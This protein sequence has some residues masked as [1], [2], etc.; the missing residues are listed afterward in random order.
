MQ[1]TGVLAGMTI[2]PA[3][4][5]E[6]IILVGITRMMPDGDYDQEQFSG[7]ASI[8]LQ[9]N[10][11]NLVRIACDDGQT[12]EYPFDPRTLERAPPGEYRLRSTG[13]VIV[14]PHYLMTWTVE[15]RLDS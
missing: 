8:A 10:G 6:A 1:G 12:H 14:D 11:V 3:D 7:I 2:E 13:Q 15:P 9:S 5:E 4:L